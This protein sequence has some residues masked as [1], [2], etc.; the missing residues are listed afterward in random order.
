M[1]YSCVQFTKT[2][3]PTQTD[4]FSFCPRYWGFYRAGLKLRVIGYPEIAAIVGTAVAKGL[5][6]FYLM[7]RDG[8]PTDAVSIE[9]AAVTFGGRLKETALANGQRY[10]ASANQSDWDAI[11]NNISLCL[12]THAK[13]DPFVAYKVLEVEATGIDGDRPDLILADDA[14]PL[15]VDFKCKLTLRAEW[16]KK[17]FSKW[18]RSWQLH[19][20]A[21]RRGISRFAVCLIAPHTRQGIIYETTTIT[22]TLAMRWLA[23]ANQLWGEMAMSEGLRIEQLRGNTT[24]ANEY[25]ECV[26]WAE[27][28]SV[29]LDPSLMNLIQVERYKE[30][31]CPSP[32]SVIT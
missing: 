15:V 16:V 5:E 9:Q 11:D 28:C 4:A 12:K 24:H 32:S 7:R 22:P 18:R 23:D 6:C 8:D 14:G 29:G 21:V 30:N 1:L 20:Y 2:Y 25:G 27:A 31:S 3:S 10:V 19:H 13:R 17:E 26:Y